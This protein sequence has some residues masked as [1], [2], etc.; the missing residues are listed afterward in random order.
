[1]G[2]NET[3][4]LDKIFLRLC[5]SR[6]SMAPPQNFWE[7]HDLPILHLVTVLNQSTHVKYKIQ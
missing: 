7:N 1:M 3:F 5:T 6:S 4:F 2:Q